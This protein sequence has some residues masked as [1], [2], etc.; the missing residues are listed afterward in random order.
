M[1]RASAVTSAGVARCA[2][3][4]P[5]R[6]GVPWYT[7]GRNPLDQ[8]F[9]PSTGNPP[10]SEST[11]YAGSSFRSVPRPYSTHDPHAGRPG[12]VLPE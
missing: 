12:K 4:V 9:V 1:R 5:V 10:G 6:N 8:L 7:A 11:T 3:G 2:T